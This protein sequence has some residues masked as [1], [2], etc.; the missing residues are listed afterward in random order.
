MISQKLIDELRIIL[1]EDYGKGLEMKE[2]A[3]IANSLV[4]YFNLLAKIHR[5]E[6]N[7]RRNNYD[8]SKPKN[9]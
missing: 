5:R 4:S 1:E 3:Q 2:V 8:D 9:N 7:L 6:E